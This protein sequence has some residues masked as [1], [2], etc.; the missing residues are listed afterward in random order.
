MKSDIKIKRMLWLRKK[1]KSGLEQMET[2]Y[3]ELQDDKSATQVVL[4]R[5]HL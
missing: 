2:G 3:I 5:K 1:V 4:V